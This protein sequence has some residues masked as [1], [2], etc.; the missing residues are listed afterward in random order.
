MFNT[1]LVDFLNQRHKLVLL[2]TVIDWDTLDTQFGQ[3][4]EPIKGAPVLPTRLVAGLHYLKHA[5]RLSDEAVVER[6]V[7]NPYWQ[8]FCGAEY[9]QYELPCPPSSLT[10]WRQRI[11]AEGCEWM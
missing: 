10:K 11:G 3:F 9:F 1:P 5:Y 2:A 8:L 6:W 7:E 4:F